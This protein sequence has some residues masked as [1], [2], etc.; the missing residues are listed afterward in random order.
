MEENCNFR[1]KN[2]RSFFSALVFSANLKR[3]GNYANRL[4]KI[5]KL[6][7]SLQYHKVICVF[8]WDQ[9]PE[10]K[11]FWREI[12]FSLKDY[13]KYERREYEIQQDKRRK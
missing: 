9:S 2:G 10:G 13:K 1:F 12:Y 3:G 11:E 6:C 7:A 8:K 4:D 5:I